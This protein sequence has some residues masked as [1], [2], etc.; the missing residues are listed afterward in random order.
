MG[1]PCATCAG[2]GASCC[3]GNQIGLTLGDVRRIAAFLGHDAFF[4]LEAAEP[5]YLAVS[6]DPH[7]LSL[8]VDPDGRRRVLK[9]A[10]DHRCSMLTDRGCK[11]STIVRPL[12]CCLHP[13]HYTESG[14]TGIVASCPI[15]GEAHWPVVLTDLGMGASQAQEWHRLLYAELRMEYSASPR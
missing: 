12:I 1:H 6:D 4:F 7:W 8:T 5:E 9:R 10:A 3:E 2:N 15:S 11:L 14:I 13:Y